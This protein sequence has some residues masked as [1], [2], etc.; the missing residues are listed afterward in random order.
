MNEAVAATEDLS[1]TLGHEFAQPALLIEALTHASALGRRSHR[2][3][4]KLRGYERLEFLGDRVLGLVVAELLWRRFPD[5]AEGPLTRR[6][7]QLVRR[8]TLTEVAREIDL[9]RHVILSSGE[10]A[11][12]TAEGGGILAD[13]CEAVIAALYLDGGLPAAARFIERHWAPRIEAASSPPRDPKTALQE[14]AQGRGLGLP[15]YETIKTEGPPHERH[16]TVRVSVTTLSPQTATGTSKRAAEIAAAAA[17][18]AQ[19]A[20]EGTR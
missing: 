17:L 12:R 7:T 10:Q 15:L 4:A 8:E 9:A 6:H 2:A 20:P 11:A 16:F 14:W 5:E 3:P 13:V 1:A 19:I 18:L